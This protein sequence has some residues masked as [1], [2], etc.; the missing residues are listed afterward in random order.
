MWYI[1]KDEKTFYEEETQIRNFNL[2]YAYTNLIKRQEERQVLKRFNY[3]VI[4]A[5]LLKLLNNFFRNLQSNKSNI[6]LTFFYLNKNRQNKMRLKRR[7]KKQYPLN[8]KNY[9]Q[10]F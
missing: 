5:F 9:G 4:I 2:D 1:Y 6:A 3:F 8:Y 7:I 10:K